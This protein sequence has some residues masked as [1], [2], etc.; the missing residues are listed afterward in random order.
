M[1]WFFLPESFPF[2]ESEWWE[3]TGTLPTACWLSN[4]F[5][6]GMNR[7]FHKKRFPHNRCL[8]VCSAWGQGT[9]GTDML[10]YG[11]LIISQFKSKETTLTFDRTDMFKLLLLN[12]CKFFLKKPFAVLFGRTW[13]HFDPSNCL[14]SVRR[15]LFLEVIGSWI[16]PC[17][18]VKWNQK[19]Q[20]WLCVISLSALV[21]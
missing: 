11:K 12:S 20:R 17:D 6:V 13:T 8:C 5:H 2:P 18:G 7:L 9:A 16:M 4:V 14:S 21:N 15:L 19:R 1:Q 3:T 10:L